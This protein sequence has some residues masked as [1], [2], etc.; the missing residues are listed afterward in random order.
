ME[1]L[2]NIN[3]TSTVETKKVDSTKKVISENSI[4]AKEL[5]EKK[6]KK[7]KLQ[8]KPISTSLFS[9]LETLG[10]NS[11]LDTSIKGTSK[12]FIYLHLRDNKLTEVQ[13]KQ[14]RNKTRSTLLKLVNS[15]EIQSK[16]LSNTKENKK[17]LQTKLINSFDEFFS[18]Y[19]KTY[20]NNN[21]ADKT[22]FASLGDEKKSDVY[23]IID[24]ILS[25]KKE[26]DSLIKK[27]K[28][29]IQ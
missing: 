7:D 15:I 10:K 25:N 6:Q 27:H 14:F 29:V 1:N 12:E 28:L 24:V 19:A 9:S 22:K 4:K 26:L 23:K 13:R 20:I 17:D 18:F 11:K 5:L 8:N 3:P 16:I 21:I 2:T